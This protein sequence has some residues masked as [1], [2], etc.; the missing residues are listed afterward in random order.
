VVIRTRGKAAGP[1][2][3]TI[4]HASLTPS[5]VSIEP[6]DLKHTSGARWSLT[7]PRGSADA[8]YVAYRLA[9]EKR[10]GGQKGIR[11]AMTPLQPDAP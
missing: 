2:D 1:I 11:I 10:D 7:V 9:Q 8:Q 6:N 5:A 4:R 3:Y